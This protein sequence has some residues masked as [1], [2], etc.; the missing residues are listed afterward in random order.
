MIDRRTLSV[1]VASSEV[2]GFAKTGGLAD[3]CGY[4][5]RALARRGHRAAVIM[6]LYRSVR[7]GPH[8]LEPTDHWLAIP[9]RGQ[10]IPVRLWKTTLP[11]SDVTVYLTEQKELFERDDP[12]QGRNIY[13]LTTPDGR[14][15][16]YPDNCNRYTVFCRAVMEAIPLLGFAPDILHANDWQTALLPVYQ[17]EL[18]QHRPGYRQIRSLMT[19]HNIA[20]QGVFKSWEFPVTGFPWRLFNHHQME[21]YGQLNFLKSGLVFADWLNTVSP[22][23]AQ[24]IQTTYFGCG[25]EGVL[26]ERNHKLSGI[27]NGVDYAT[28]NPATDKLLP[29]N[30]T[31]ANVREG[32]TACKAELQRRF[33]LPVDGRIPV[34]GMIARLVEQKGIELVLKTADELFHRPVQIVILGEGEPEYHHRLNE[35]KHRYPDRIGLLLGFDESLAHQIEA[36][37][38]LYLMPSL[39]EPSGLNQLYSLKYGTPP[40]VRATGGLADTITDATEENLARDTATG[41]RFHSFT[42]QSYLEAVHRGLN[43]YEQQPERFLQVVRCGMRQD[44]SWDRAAEGYEALYQNLITQRE[45]HPQHYSKVSGS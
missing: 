35:L 23:Y 22:T 12:S 4:L 7:N 6:P 13:Q 19:I 8:R 20:Y 43:L 32:K 11:D 2:V 44:W 29:L 1:L 39:F 16:D 34:L 9:L 30:Y 38:D 10:S 41:F 42:P 33:N 45:L 17:H 21:F 37:S 40:I 26:T 28:W 24:E 31:E 27:V 3:V 25:L 5:P 18:Y 15:Q 36:G 14:K